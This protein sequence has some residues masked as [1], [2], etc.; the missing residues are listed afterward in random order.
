MQTVRVGEALVHFFYVLILP[1]NAFFVRV[2]V[3]G[4]VATHAYRLFALR[5]FIVLFIERFQFLGN[6]I[7]T[8]TDTYYYENHKK[9][10]NEDR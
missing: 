4:Q 10:D 2:L 5:F 3:L 8:R 1:C 6:E 9:T 7:W